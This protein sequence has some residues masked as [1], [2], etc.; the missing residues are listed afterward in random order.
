MQLESKPLFEEFAKYLLL[1][2]CGVF[3]ATNDILQCM[4]AAKYEIIP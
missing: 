2:N 4:L 1:L 3:S